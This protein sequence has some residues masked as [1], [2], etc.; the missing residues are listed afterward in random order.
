MDGTGLN[1]GRGRGWHTLAPRIQPMMLAYAR[2]ALGV[3]FLS[4]VADRFG[5]WGA[6][7]ALNVAWGNF[8]AFLQYTARLNPYLPGALVPALGVAVTIAEVVLGAALVAGIHVR[9]AANASGFLLLAFALGMT[10]G[11]GLKSALD[12]SVFAASA[13]SFLLASASAA[14]IDRRRSAAES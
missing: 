14:P 8:D 10:V 1:A 2:I 13:A 5:A 6:R 12:A 7:G 4:A 3:G 11:T 9:L